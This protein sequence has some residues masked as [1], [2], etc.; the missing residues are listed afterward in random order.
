MLEADL[1]AR[2]P[3]AASGSLGSGTPG[4]SSSTPDSFSSA[5]LADWKVL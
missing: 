4:S 1:A 3:A 5:A 2:R